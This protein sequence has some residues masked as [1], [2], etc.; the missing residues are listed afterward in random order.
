MINIQKNKVAIVL[1]KRTAIGVFNRTFK[2]QNIVD[3]TVEAIKK[4]IDNKIIREINSVIFGMVLQAGNGQNVARQISIKSGVD[5]SASSYTVN[6]VCGS[7]MKAITLG[8]QE[9]LLNESDAVLVGGLE[10]M[11][12]ALAGTMLKDGLTDAFYNIH[13][14]ITAENVAEKYGLS[15]EELDEFSLKS[16]QKAIK[17]INEGKFKEEIVEVAGVDEDKFVKKDQSIEKLKSLKS[18]FK[19]NGVV[20]A[21][22][23]TGINDGSAFLVLMDIKKANELDLEILAYVNAYASCGLDPKYMG[24]GPV[25]AIRKLL[26][27]ENLKIEDIDL[28]EINEAFATQSIAVARELNIDENKLNIN[29]GSIA[30]GHPIGASGARIVVTLLNEMKRQNLKRGVASLCI[31]GGQG[32]AILVER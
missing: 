2:E 15:R 1:A 21:G 20:T 18:I 31:G 10:S 16:T 11:S 9:I 29:G 7:G 6:M 22:N 13:M 4:T 23:A 8:S 14:G 32:I 19:E 5:E 28:F 27:K 30:L 26:E 17:A 3:L 25:Y 12:N 24:L